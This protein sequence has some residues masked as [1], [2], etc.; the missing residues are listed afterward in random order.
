M[1]GFSYLE[2]QHKNQKTHR[3]QMHEVRE[4]LP[5]LSEYLQEPVV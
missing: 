1:I 2:H 4:K 5:P 3:L